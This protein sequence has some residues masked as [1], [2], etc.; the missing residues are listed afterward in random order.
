MSVGAGR[1][2]AAV[3]LPLRGVKAL[4]KAYGATINDMVLTLCSGALRHYLEGQAKLL[5]KRA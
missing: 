1:A 5:Q 3:T 2:F 4:G